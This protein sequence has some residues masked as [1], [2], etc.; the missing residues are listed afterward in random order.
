MNSIGHEEKVITLEQSHDEYTHQILGQFLE[1]FVQKCVETTGT[2]RGQEIMMRA[3]LN[4]EIPSA[5]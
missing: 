2:I 4:A 1:Q 5:T 3:A